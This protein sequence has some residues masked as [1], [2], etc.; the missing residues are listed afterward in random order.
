MKSISQPDLFDPTLGRRLREEGMRRVKANAG[1][2]WRDLYRGAITRWF[3]RLEAGHQ[4]SSE[5]LRTVARMA[6]VG[7]PHHYNAWSSMA[8]HFIREWLKTG[9]VCITGEGRAT[10]PQGHATKVTE[11]AKL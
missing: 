11:Y 8:G 2:I 1:E 6:G 7:E 10:R 5:T 3:W 9:R 4:F